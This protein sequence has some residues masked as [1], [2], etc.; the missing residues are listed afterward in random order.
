M[1]YSV[2]VDDFEADAITLGDTSPHDFPSKF[3][4]KN[5][6]Q[7]LADPA[8]TGVIYVGKADVNTTGRSFPLTAGA[9][10]FMP[11]A[12]LKVLHLLASANGQKLWYFAS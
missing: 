8:N 11:I 2:A 3:V 6:V 7:L 10:Q 1:I 4:C 12:D 9:S 5:G